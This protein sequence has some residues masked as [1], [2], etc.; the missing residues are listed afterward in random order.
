MD[1][2]CTV[3]RNGYTTI[4]LVVI[5]IDTYTAM[6]FELRLGIGLLE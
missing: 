3:Q 1:K 5:N 4:H 6:I 2:L